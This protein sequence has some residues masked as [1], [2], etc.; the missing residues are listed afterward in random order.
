M[1]CD[2]HISA[3]K[4]DSVEGNISS[5]ILGELGSDL[6]LIRFRLVRFRFVCYNISYAKF[7]LVH[8]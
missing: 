6:R 1:I 7:R 2:K 8:T 5:H 4:Y 3:T